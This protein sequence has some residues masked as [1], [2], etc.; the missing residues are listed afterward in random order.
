MTT[1]WQHCPACGAGGLGPFGL[2]MH[3][4]RRHPEQSTPT[5]GFSPTQVEQIDRCRADT[6]RI[7]S[8][9]PQPVV[10][11][12]EDIA[13]ALAPVWPTYADRLYRIA[14]TLTRE[15]TL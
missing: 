13:D 6:V 3:L 12:L 8:A 11:E 5:L 9:A 14:G 4:A 15:A 7:N 1:E 2:A 10:V